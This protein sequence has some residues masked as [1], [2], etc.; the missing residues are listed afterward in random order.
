MDISYYIRE[1][2]EFLNRDYFDWAIQFAK[3]KY[4]W[5]VGDDLKFILP[6]WDKAIFDWLDIYYN[7]RPFDQGLPIKDDIVYINIKCDTPKPSDIDWDFSCFPI[8][9]RKAVEAT[10]FF[11][12]PEIP[13]WCS[14][15]PLA[16]LYFTCNRLMNISHQF[17][18][19]QGVETEAVIGDKITER[20]HKIMKKYDSSKLAEKWMKEKLPYYANRIYDEVKIAMINY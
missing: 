10:G 12:I 7:R 17:F 2:T 15:Y 13:S 20:L 19:H 16:K 1:R 8:I 3:G 5:N 18:K 4:F 11:L 9:S 14:D 6:E